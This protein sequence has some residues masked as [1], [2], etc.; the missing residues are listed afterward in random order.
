MLTGRR[1]MSD[2]YKKAGVNID[3]GNDFVQRIKPFVQATKRHGV[4]TELGGFAGFFQP[5]L[6][7]LKEPVLVSGTDGVGTK[8]MLAKELND[9]SRI[10]IDLVAMCINDIACSGATPLF[11]LDYLATGKLDVDLHARVVEG[12]AEGCKQAKCALIG[13]ETAEMPGC[14][15]GTDFDL[16]G[17]AVGIV[18]RSN[19]IDG[20]EIRVGQ[21]II[22]VASSGFHSNGY[23]LVRNIL[24]EH[25][26][27]LSA[28]L[29]NSNTTIG[30][31]LLE[32]TFI[33][34]SLIT[35]LLRQFS[36]T[37]I[38]HITG[39]GFWDN[40]PRIL[41]P[42][43]MASIDSSSWKR[44]P[45]VSFLQEKANI[46]EAEMLRVFNT[47]IGLVLI[48]PEEQS[49]SVCDFIDGAQHKAWIIGD[50][51]ASDTN[52]PIHFTNL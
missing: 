11:F 40:I 42:R 10:G 50:I 22:G 5:D 17:F 33:Y 19:I 21:K 31:A 36:L 16:A 23:S 38:V 26:I 46:A 27:D 6:A 3:A 35:Q 1:N 41:P 52:T 51:K 20:T 34:S 9:V 15:Q 44:P 49:Q 37:G 25:H 29:E 39:G 2:S 7:D 12:I 28:P 30:K 4:L 8:L 14:Y 13:G 32:P 48:V 43:L 47:G 18:D 45:V 24:K